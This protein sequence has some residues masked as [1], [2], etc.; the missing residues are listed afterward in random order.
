MLFDRI[1]LSGMRPSRQRSEG[2][3]RAALLWSAR[4]LFAQRGFDGASTRQIADRAKVQQGLVRHHFGSKDALWREVVAAGLA[5]L[6]AAVAGA[7]A[8]SP[9][10]PSGLA[11][12]CGDAWLEQRELV[13]LVLH[14]LLEPGERREWLLAQLDASTA[15]TALLARVQATRDREPSAEERAL[16]A[17]RTLVV[18]ALPLLASG[19]HALQGSA[20]DAASIAR[21]QQI[22]WTGLRAPSPAMRNPGPWSLAAAARRRAQSPPPHARAA[23]D[24]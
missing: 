15:A 9:H 19:W 11:V 24:S 23:R 13:S 5:Q 22:A 12:R 3:A 18:C 17:L 21:L 10:E 2:S 8:E 20:L 4:A 6:D 7:D 16:L 14:A 1:G